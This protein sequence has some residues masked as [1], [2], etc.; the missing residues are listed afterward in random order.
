M[1]I[2][3]VIVVCFVP[4]SGILVVGDVLEQCLVA[5]CVL[6]VVRLEVCLIAGLLPWSSRKSERRKCSTVRKLITSVNQSA[7][8]GPKSINLDRFHCNCVCTRT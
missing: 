6:G 4:C 8:G 7:M 3:S 5:G 1:W 2:V